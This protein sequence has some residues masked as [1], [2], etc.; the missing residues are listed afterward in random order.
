[1]FKGQMPGFL[2]VSELS[3]GILD[4]PLQNLTDSIKISRIIQY[5]T[6]SLLGEMPLMDYRVT[7]TGHGPCIFPNFQGSCESELMP[8]AD[9]ALQ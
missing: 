2:L 3:L 5:S 1:M 8:R 6:L 7:A 9:M 4:N